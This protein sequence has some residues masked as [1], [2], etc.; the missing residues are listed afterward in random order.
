MHSAIIKVNMLTHQVT[1]WIYHNVF[2][3]VCSDDNKNNR[4]SEPLGSSV[5]IYLLLVITY[6]CA[7]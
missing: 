1:K 7:G 5:I 2:E 3:F 4:I 6:C